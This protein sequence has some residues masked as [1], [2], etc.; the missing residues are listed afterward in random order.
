MTLSPVESVLR[1]IDVRSVNKSV[2]RETRNREAYYPPVGVYRWWARRSTS[3]FR[4]IVGAFNRDHPG[5]CLI[6]DPFAGGGVIPLAAI[7]EGHRVYAQDVNPW[8]TEGMA[9]MLSLPSGRAI[10]VAAEELYALAKATLDR[11]Y[12]TTLSDGT[13]GVIGHTFRVAT[14]CCPS[15]QERSAMYP[16]ALV[17]LLSRKELKKDHAILA[18]PAGHLFNG[19]IDRQNRCEICGLKTDPEQIYTRGR[20]T[21]CIKCGHN[22]KLTDRALSGS[23]RW[24][25]VLVERLAQHRRELA[26]PSA[27]EKDQAEN[28]QWVPHRGLGSILPG[29]ETQVL[30]RHG[31]RRWEDLYPARQRVV[32]EA[33]FDIIPLASSDANVAEALRWAVGGAVEMAG[34]LSR[35]D[36]YYLKSY[37]SMAGH[38]FN[39]TTFTAEQNVWG[40]NTWGRGP[41][42]K[43]LAMFAKASDWLSGRLGRKLKIEGPLKGTERRTV[44]SKAT[45][46]RV[47]LGSSERMPIT[48]NCADLVLTDPPYHDDVQYDDLSRPLRSWVGLPTERPLGDAV[49]NG[50]GVGGRGADGY[51]EIITKVFSEARRTLRVNGRLILS[52][53]N[54]D[55]RAWADLFSALQSAGFRALGHVAVLSENDKDFPKRKV[56]ACRMDLIMELVPASNRERISYVPSARPRSA[57]GDYL[58]VVARTFMNVGKLTDGWEADFLRKCRSCRFLADRVGRLAKR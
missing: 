3:S 41:V 33:L 31:F 55:P 24:D 20:I 34:L 37:G 27:V 25:V 57:E 40:L 58:D 54:R 47:V 4:A 14:A 46:V 53:A 10:R 51:R 42:P 29:R 19:L 8:A 1:H 39:F 45:D 32:L 35:W 26:I 52:Y 13:P 30:L 38:R 28:D 36:R 5:R 6:A 43:R 44:M 23:W 2:R 17:S 18:C 22:D 56:R 9:R 48:N 50:L 16:H 21:T 49:P 15:C 12:S 11:A 7:L